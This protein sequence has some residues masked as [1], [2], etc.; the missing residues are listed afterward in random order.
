MIGYARS[1]AAEDRGSGF[2]AGTGPVMPAVDELDLE[3][4]E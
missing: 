1:T 4:G 3:G 2:G